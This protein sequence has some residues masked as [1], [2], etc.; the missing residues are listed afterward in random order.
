[1]K[2][3]VNASWYLNVTH[4]SISAESCCRNPAKSGLT[5]A[6]ERLSFMG[7][8]GRSLP[9]HIALTVSA[10]A[11]A[12]APPVPNTLSTLISLTYESFRKGITTG[13]RCARHCTVE[14]M[15]HELPRLRSP[16]CPPHGPRGCSALSG[17]PFHLPQFR[18]WNGQCASW[19]RRPQYFTTLHLAQRCLAFPGAKQAPQGITPF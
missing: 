8:S 1:M 5:R 11:L 16:M 9:C 19:Q 10:H 4:P 14:F 13:R 15:K 12:N 6:S 3:H 17:S 7:A 2:V 18:L